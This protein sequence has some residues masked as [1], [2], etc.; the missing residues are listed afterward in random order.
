MSGMTFL[1]HDYETF[2]RD[3]RRDRP[4]QFAG[5]R[6][7]AELNVVGEPVMWYCQPT[8]DVLP[9]PESCLLTGI[10]PQHCAQHGLP[11]HRFAAQVEQQ[12]GL[13]GTIGVGYNSLRFDD[14]VTRHLLW[15]NLIDPYA[16][17]W[18]DG[19]G[20]WDLMDVLRCAWALRPDGLVWPTYEDGRASFR[21]ED[22]TR[23]NGV[24]HDDA[25]DALADV[26][27]T[28]AMARLVKTHQPKL[29]AFC[30]RLC[31]KEAVQEEI[32]VQRP[33]A[34]LSGRYPIERGCLAV[35]WP[36]AA[37][38]TN[39]NELIVWDL[40]HDPRELQGLDPADARRRLFS[41]QE[42]LPEGET[43]LPIKTI[44]LNRSPVVMSNLRTVESAAPRWGLD[45]AQAVARVPQAAEVSAGLDAEWWQAVYARE[46]SAGPRDVDEDLYGGFIG[47]ADRRTLER[48]RTLTPGELAG[49]RL[50][51]DDARL[52]EL[53]FRYRARNFPETLTDDDA[54]RWDAHRRARLVDGAGGSLTLQAFLD[55]IDVLHEN[56]DERGEEILSALVDYAESIAP[57]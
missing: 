48:L 1:W 55:R 28:L 57:D 46:A 31:R 18:R 29:W 39:R 34:H 23:A 50:G 37:H 41:R 52:E 2:G 53:V 44:H 54:E 9:D 26:R 13:P 38:P 47:N 35:V 43:R 36:L 22:L 3:P 17:E 40:S 12:L 56:A 20:R 42:D 49:K 45:V 21:L 4:A 7:D 15:R 30:L 14:E 10:L 24:A 25:H 16:R 32:G 33:F 5:L 11:E 27:A 51:F 8:P 19:C 6:T